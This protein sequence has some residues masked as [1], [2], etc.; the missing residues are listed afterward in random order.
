MS[1]ISRKMTLCDLVLAGIVCNYSK[2]LGFA[3]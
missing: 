2:H 1:Q 3:I